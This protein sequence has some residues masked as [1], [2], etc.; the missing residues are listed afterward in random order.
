[1][2][3][4]NRQPARRRPAKVAGARSQ[5]VDRGSRQDG[6]AGPV[7]P[8]VPATPV[9]EARAAVEPAPEADADPATADASTADASTTDASTTDP[10]T[11][12]ADTAEADTAA[13]GTADAAERTSLRKAAPA[14]TAGTTA[15]TTKGRG[16]ARADR[17]GA[18]T[19]ARATLDAAAPDR[20]TDGTTGDDATAPAASSAPRRSRP[21]T[22]ALAL[23]GVLLVAALVVGGVALVSDGGTTQDAPTANVAL[24]DPAATAEASAATVTILQTA[25]SYTWSSI[26]ADLDNAVALM[27]PEMATQH[28]ASFASIRQVVTDSQTTTQAT[29]V[30]NGVK[31][32]DGDRAEV[33]AFVTVGGDNAGTA[34]QTAGYRFT[35]NLLRV[36]GRWLLSGLQES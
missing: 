5:G 24:V 31:L 16:G 33:I 27:T 15:P 22:A 2:P 18:S 26:D 19:T 1:M 11:A 17:T 34:L 12:E 29:V 32:L 7:D 3:P 28:R 20:A 36:D 14:A 8:E 6:P 10:A 21:V 23:A 35:A 25:Y 9:D 4:V 30:Q 13:P